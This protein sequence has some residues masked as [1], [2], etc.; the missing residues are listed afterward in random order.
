MTIT[1]LLAMPAI[2]CLVAEGWIFYRLVIDLTPLGK[3]SVLAMVAIAIGLQM[4]FS[5]WVFRVWNP[6]IK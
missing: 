3:F 5:M 2:S 6:E 4:L 1:E